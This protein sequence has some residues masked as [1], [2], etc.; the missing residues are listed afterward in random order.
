MNAVGALPVIAAIDHHEKHAALDARYQVY[1]IAFAERQAEPEDIEGRA[2]VFHLQPR[3]VAQDGM[4]AVGADGEP[5]A[6]LHVTVR[7]RRQ[8][9][10]DAVALRD[11]VA[12]LGLH[13]EIEIGILLRLVGDEIHEVSLRHQGDELAHRGQAGEIT[14]GEMLVAEIQGHMPDLGMR[15]LQEA[16]QQS[17]LMHDLL[18]GGVHRVAAEI[19]QEI[20][21]LFQHRHIYPGAGQQ[22]ASHHAGGA[23]TGNDT[24]GR[25]RFHGATL[26]YKQGPALYFVLQ[27]F[28]RR[29]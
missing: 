4:A 17:Q 19:A 24:T 1:R 22:I 21:M 29:R 20:G 7:S 2:Q 6:D 18:G 25:E 14:D 9:A 27:Q 11:Q 15:Q 12:R 5:G 8:H 13:Q 3:F 26:L 16:L 23:A 10:G 28:I